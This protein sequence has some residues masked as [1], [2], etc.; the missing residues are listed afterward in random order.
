MTASKTTG[1]TFGRASGLALLDQCEG[2][3]AAA[4]WL[5]HGSSV[6]A[7]GK[8]RARSCVDTDNLV[9]GRRRDAWGG[10]SRP[11]RCAAASFRQHTNMYTL[12]ER[13]HW[14]GSGHLRQPETGW[15]RRQKGD[16]SSR[17]RF[18]GFGM[19]RGGLLRREQRRRSTA[20]RQRAF[21]VG[22]R[23]DRGTAGL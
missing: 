19:A 4:T 22:P 7:R 17:H 6:Y 21:R 12:Q 20:G 5:L 3:A 13:E 11:A 10:T 8:S 23:V 14:F 2:W 9:S 18:V 15:G 16:P 1:S